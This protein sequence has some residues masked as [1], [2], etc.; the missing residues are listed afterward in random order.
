MSIFE[1]HGNLG[2]KY[3]FDDSVSKVFALSEIAAMDLISC[4]YW[5]LT[6]MARSLKLDDTQMDVV[7]GLA[8]TFEML[9][10][11]QIKDIAVS[12][13][14]KTAVCGVKQTPDLLANQMIARYTQDPL[15]ILDLI[16]DS[17]DVIWDE[18]EQMKAVGR[19]KFAKFI[20]MSFGN[21]L[22]MVGIPPVDYRVDTDLPLSKVRSKCDAVLSHCRSIRKFDPVRGQLM[23]ALA[24]IP[25][26]CYTFNGDLIAEKAISTVSGVFLDERLIQQVS[27]ELPDLMKM[28]AILPILRDPYNFK[29]LFKSVML[30]DGYLQIIREFAKGLSLTFNNIAFDKKLNAKEQRVVDKFQDNMARG[31]YSKDGMGVQDSSRY[32]MGAGIGAAVGMS[33]AQ[34]MIGNQ[35]VDIY[36]SPGVFQNTLDNISRRRAE[37]QQ[38]YGEQ[39]DDIFGVCRQ[40]QRSAHNGY[41]EPAQQVNNMYQRG[42]QQGN[43]YEYGYEGQRQGQQQPQQGYYTQSQQQQ[44]DNRGIYGGQQQSRGNQNGQR[45]QQGY[46]QQQGYQQGQGY[47]QG[48]AQRQEY[49][50]QPNFAPTMRV[51]DK[52]LANS[53]AGMPTLLAMGGQTFDFS[54]LGVSRDMEDNSTASAR[55]KF[56][57]LVQRMHAD[58][59]TSVSVIFQDSRTPEV[60]VSLIE[61]LKANNSCKASVSYYNNMN[62]YTTMRVSYLKKKTNSKRDSSN[63]LDSLLFTDVDTGRVQGKTQP[64]QRNKQVDESANIFDVVSNNNMKQQRTQQQRSNAFDDLETSTF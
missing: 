18:L 58:A 64:A 30:L 32:A 15:T 20:C 21:I 14:K 45:Q 34:G 63:D 8:K 46:P 4:T 61:L 26:L 54:V 23:E 55:N 62:Q 33:T 17:N 1:K 31:M 59:Y 50:Q 10:D 57:N 49:T 16:L 37:T 3:S 48:Y 52:L 11:M 13:F 28:N 56:T 60:E 24:Y 51:I 7:V 22:D 5:K 27:Q 9:T 19:I 41:R 36:G 40:E 39:A 53:S 47:P 44:R 12:A 2:A 43:G 25:V 35:R 38:Y 29:L 42:R 6:R